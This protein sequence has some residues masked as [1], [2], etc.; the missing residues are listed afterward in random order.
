MSAPPGDLVIHADGVREEQQVR[1][2]VGSRAV[3]G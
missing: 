1:M 3:S 2:V